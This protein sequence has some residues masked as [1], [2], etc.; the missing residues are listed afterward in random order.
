MENFVFCVVIN[1]Q[2]LRILSSINLTKEVTN[3]GIKS[4]LLENSSKEVELRDFDSPEG[5]KI[6]CAIHEF[7]MSASVQ[8]SI[9]NR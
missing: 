4:R 3:T 2:K 5:K 1:N 8:K 6:P 7:L 9:R